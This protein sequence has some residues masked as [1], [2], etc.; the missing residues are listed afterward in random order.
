MPVYLLDAAGLVD[1]TP[2]A[3]S[4]AVEA[5]QD[6][7]PAAL[8]DAQALLR[9]GAVRVVIANAQ[10]GGAETTQ[11]IAAAKAQ[12]IPVLEFA[13]TLPSGDTYLTWMRQ[14]IADLAKAVAR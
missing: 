9:S 2:S 11:V 10:T 14:N 13:E 1:A 8:L 3:F 4:S 6:V 5:G 12:S 7:P